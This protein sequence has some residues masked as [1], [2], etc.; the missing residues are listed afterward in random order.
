MNNE[1]HQSQNYQK[2]NEYQFINNM[3]FGAKKTETIKVDNTS[4]KDLELVTK[5][6]QE[7][8]KTLDLKET[9]QTS[10]ELIIK[11]INAQAA[12]IFLINIFLTDKGKLCSLSPYKMPGRKPSNL[13]F[14][15][16]PFVLSFLSDASSFK[17]SI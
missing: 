13:N 17:F 14:L 6:G 10:L 7:F 16:S 11:R 4:V 8:A 12:N 1:F 5:M 3:F 2:F 15:R 9:L